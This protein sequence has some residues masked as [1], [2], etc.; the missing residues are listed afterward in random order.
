MIL[1][2]M[3]KGVYSGL[4]EH[5]LVME[6]PDYML[7]S[8]EEYGVDWKEGREKAKEQQSETIEDQSGEELNEL[9][10]AV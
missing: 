9:P 3:E 5:E 7:I 4:C 8:E 6:E 1:A 2:M 10:E